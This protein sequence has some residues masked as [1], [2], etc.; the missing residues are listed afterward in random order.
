MQ[1]KVESKREHVFIK[2]IKFKQKNL[3]GYR[4]GT[5]SGKTIFAQTVFPIFSR[6]HYTQSTIIKAQNSVLAFLIL[7]LYAQST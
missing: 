4:L 3:R 6:S 2:N 1:P 5:V 7:G